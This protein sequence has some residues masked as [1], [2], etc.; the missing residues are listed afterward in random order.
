MLFSSILGTTYLPKYW[1]SFNEIMYICWDISFI[2]AITFWHKTGNA[3]HRMSIFLNLGNYL[4]QEVLGWFWWNF[5]PPCSAWRSIRLYWDV[6]LC[7]SVCVCVCVSVCLH[8]WANISG[9]TGPIWMKFVC[10]GWILGPIYDVKQSCHSG[11]KFAG[12]DVNCTSGWTFWLLSGK[13]LGRFWWNFVCW[14]G[15][16]YKF[17]CYH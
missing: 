1:V 5:I 16:T 17:H 15:Y 11:T 12:Y 14:L 6:C 9:T 13:L 7:V 10:R 3:N 4:S 2:A 8:I